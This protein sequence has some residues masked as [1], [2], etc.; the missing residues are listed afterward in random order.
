MSTAYLFVVIVVRGKI[1]LLL[2]KSNRTRIEIE[3]HY[4]FFASSPLATKQ[5]DRLEWGRTNEAITWS[6][7]CRWIGRK[8]EICRTVWLTRGSS[9]SSSGSDR[10]KKQRNVCLW[11]QISTIHSNVCCLREEYCFWESSHSPSTFPARS[12][13]LSFSLSGISH[14]ARVGLLG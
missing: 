5:M 13:A 8:F 11:S 9:S 6:R 1:R 3:I 4:F 2:I 7:G 12:L 14:A 10:R